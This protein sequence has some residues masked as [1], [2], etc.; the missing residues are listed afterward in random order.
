MFLSYKKHQAQDEDLQNFLSNK[1]LHFHNCLLLHCVRKAFEPQCVPGVAP[2]VQ[3]ASL[4]Q[5]LQLPSQSFLA[6]FSQAAVTE[7]QQLSAQTKHIL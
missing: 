3:T 1:D 6:P 2:S 5:R 4:Q 7:N